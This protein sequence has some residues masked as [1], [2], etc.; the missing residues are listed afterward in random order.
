MSEGKKRMMEYYEKKAIKHNDET[1]TKG[2]RL[3]AVRE[4][5]GLKYVATWA[6]TGQEVVDR[7]EEGYMDDFIY[8][9]M[10]SFYRSV[11]SGLGKEHLI[12]QYLE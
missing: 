7:A 3:K 9:Y 12:K 11:A 6:M 8:D 2:K 10:M 5:L 1:I 4:A